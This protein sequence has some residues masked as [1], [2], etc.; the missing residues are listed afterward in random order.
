RARNREGYDQVGPVSSNPYGSP[1]ARVPDFPSVILSPNARNLVTPSW[2]VGVG[3]VTVMNEGVGPVAPLPQA[4]AKAA[5]MRTNAFRV[6][7][8]TKPSVRASMSE[9]AMST[10]AGTSPQACAQR[11]DD[12]LLAFVKIAVTAKT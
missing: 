12:T 6:R 8:R 4:P 10:A 2:G 5:T 1:I 9:L 7:R 11:W 3:P